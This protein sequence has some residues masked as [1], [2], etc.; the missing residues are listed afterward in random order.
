M[1]IT[2]DM[3]KEAYK[4]A[5]KVPLKQISFSQA[6]I[7]INKS[8]GMNEGS[9][10]AFLTIFLAMLNGEEYKRAFNNETNKFLLNS[11]RRDY[12]EAAFKNALN[13]AQKHIDYYST[14]G[15][16]NLKGLQGIVDELC[17]ELNEEN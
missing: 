8:T 11:I 12:G 2:L 13:A 7:E 1:K 4:I 6:K 15:N 10:H 14:L 3:S 5:K 17:K 16:G 9:A